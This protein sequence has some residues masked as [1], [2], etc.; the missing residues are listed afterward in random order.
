MKRRVRGHAFMDEDTDGGRTLEK[1]R[2][3][4]GFVANK[5]GSFGLRQPAAALMP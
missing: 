3:L 5:G 4:T 2:G 1:N